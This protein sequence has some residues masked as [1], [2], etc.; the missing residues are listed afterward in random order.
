MQGAENAGP[1]LFKY[2]SGS[3]DFLLNFE[4]AP[5]MNR[6]QV[7]SHLFQIPQLV[8]YVFFLYNS[9]QVL[10]SKNRYLTIEIERACVSDC[11]GTSTRLAGSVISSSRRHTH[12]SSNQ[13]SIV[14]IKV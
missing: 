1:K 10:E 9:L 13:T 3:F 14:K 4:L 6:H 7:K 5:E 12:A 11:K 8:F 2:M